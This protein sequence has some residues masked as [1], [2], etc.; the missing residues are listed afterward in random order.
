M[1]EPLR[2][3]EHASPFGRGPA[4]DSLAR[5]GGVVCATRQ[6]GAS[7]HKERGTLQ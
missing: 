1:T 5:G 6:G 7:P 2:A 3:A 4:P